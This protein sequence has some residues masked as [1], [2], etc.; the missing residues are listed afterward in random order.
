MSIGRF[1]SGGIRPPGNS[2]FQS[3]IESGQIRRRAARL[4]CCYVRHELA[5]PADGAEGARLPPMR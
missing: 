5:E 2:T 1:H 4:T 3:V